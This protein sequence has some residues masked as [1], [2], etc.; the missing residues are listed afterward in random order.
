MGLSV[1]ASVRESIN[2]TSYKPLV[3]GNFT[4][5]TNSLHTGKKTKCLDFE[6]KR[7]KVKV[8]G[9]N[10]TTCGHI[11]TVRHFPAC[12]RNDWTYFDETYYR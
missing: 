4:K 3:H 9:T 7:S 6:V 5:F 2:T 8:K 11:S 12:P 10:E 1:R